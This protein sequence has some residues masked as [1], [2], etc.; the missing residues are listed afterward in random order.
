MQGEKR[1]YTA[2]NYLPQEGGKSS[3]NIVCPFCGDRL[4]CFIGKIKY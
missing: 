2:N 1:E 4:Q 3:F